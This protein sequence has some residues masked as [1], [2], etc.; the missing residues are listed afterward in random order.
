MA[1][2]DTATPAADTDYSWWWRCLRP[3]L[4]AIFRCLF[5]WRIHGVGRI[6]S[7]GPALIAPNHMSFLDPL[8]F[9]LCVVRRKR[10][11]RFIT[12]AEFFP[13]RGIGFFLRAMH[14]IPIKRGQRDTKAL[15]DAKAALREGAL[16]GIYPE[17]K[18]NEHPSQLLPGRSGVARL[19]IETN[20]PILP[21]G[22]WGPQF[23]LPKSGV[24]W[25]RPLRTRVTIVFGDP[26]WPDPTDE[27]EDAIQ[28]L[29]ERVM[30]EIERLRVAAKGDTERR[31][32]AREDP[33]LA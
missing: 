24:M 13:K 31:R 14:Q 9:C 10:G 4:Q 17:G 3:P 25:R 27:S 6:P 1:E 19:A 11:I 20:T 8:F 26:I 23:R 32:G 29:T 22:I 16:V 15:D 28:R 30:E 7:G 12:A 18:I 21:A 2:T 5:A 33:A